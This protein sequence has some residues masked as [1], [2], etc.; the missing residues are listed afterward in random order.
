MLVAAAELGVVHCR[1]DC[2]L[3]MPT[4]LGNAKKLHQA[5]GRADPMAEESCGPPMCSLVS[6]VF[7]SLSQCYLLVVDMF[8]S[9]L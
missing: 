4:T 1:A 8:Q 3:M 5:M 9:L 7:K 2:Q 6:S